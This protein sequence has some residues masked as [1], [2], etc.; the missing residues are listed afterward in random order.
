MVTL[1]YDPT[2]LKPTKASLLPKSLLQTDAKE[3]E[4]VQVGTSY[5]RYIPYFL[6]LSLFLCSASGFLHLSDLRLRLHRVLYCTTRL[7]LYGVRI[8]FYYLY[9]YY[10]LRIYLQPHGQ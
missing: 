10:D 8:H 2:M 7:L 6:Y 3:L 5:I 9:Y 4:R 1:F